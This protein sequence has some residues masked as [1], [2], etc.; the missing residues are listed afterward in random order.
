MKNWTC[1]PGS[2]ENSFAL[3]PSFCSDRVSHWPPTPCSPAWPLCINQSFPES[4]ADFLL[5][6]KS[7]TQP[8]TQHVSTGGYLFQ[9]VKEIKK[10]LLT[11]ILPSIL[12]WPCQT[13]CP[14]AIWDLK[15]IHTFQCSTNQ[16]ISLVTNFVKHILGLLLVHTS[17]QLDDILQTTHKKL[18]P[19]VSHFSEYP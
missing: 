8:A 9:G 19:S 5:I 1:I 6:Y 15:G 12:M 7:T 17:Y 4:S 3:Y 11:E 18:L 2:Q 14:M 13:R 16:P 10:L